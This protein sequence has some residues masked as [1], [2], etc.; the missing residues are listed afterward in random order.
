[1]Y[2]IHPRLINIF[3]SSWR[4]SAFCFARLSGYKNNNNC[5]VYCLCIYIQNVYR[6]IYR[7][8]GETITNYVERL[9]MVFIQETFDCCGL[10][11]KDSSGDI[12]AHDGDLSFCP[13]RVTVAALGEGRRSLHYR[14]GHFIIKRGV[15]YYQ[16]DWCHDPVSIF[17]N[18]GRERGWIIN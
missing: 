8:Q 7:I 16:S 11:A 5:T 13:T 18:P 14:H 15:Y 4:D 12:N 2:L 1:V 3:G 6:I 10:A 9:C 17:I